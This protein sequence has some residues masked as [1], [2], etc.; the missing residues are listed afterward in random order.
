VI[1][2]RGSLYFVLFSFV[3]MIELV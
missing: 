3:S 1:V 2:T